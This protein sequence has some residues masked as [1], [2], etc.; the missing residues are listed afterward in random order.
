M[1]AWDSQSKYEVLDDYGYRR[2]K[3]KIAQGIGLKATGW[4]PSFYVKIRGTHEEWRS[5]KTVKG[6]SIRATHLCFVFFNS[7]VVE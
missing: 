5:T 6:V 3:V 4:V 1:F 2:L 7:L